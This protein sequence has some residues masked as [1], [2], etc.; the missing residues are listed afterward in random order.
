MKLRTTFIIPILA[1]VFS[2]V[3][4]NAQW[5]QQPFPSNENLWKVRFINPTTGWVLGAGNIYKTTDGGTSWQT[6]DTV[7]TGGGSAL[8]GLNNSIAFFAEFQGISGTTY[9]GIRKTS[10]GGISWRTVDT[11]QASYYDFDFVNQQTGFVVGGDYRQTNSCIIRKTTD[12][13]ESWQTVAALNAGSDFEGISFVDALHGWVVSYNGGLV[14]RTTDGGTS[15]AFQDNVGGNYPMRDIKFST[16]DSGWAIGGI[17]GTS[18]FAR[19]TN[20]GDSWTTVEQPGNT[21][22]E[23]TMVNSQLGWVV[24]HVYNVPPLKTTD[25]GVTWFQQQID[26]PIF[27]FDIYSISMVD[28]NLGWLAGL[29]GRVYKTMNGGTA[30]VTQLPTSPTR[31]HL[32]QNFPN[33]FNPST[34]I[35]FELPERSVV[36][37]IIFDPLGREVDDLIEGSFDAGSHSIMWNASNFSSGVYFVRMTVNDKS[38]V[39]QFTKTNKL[40][41]MK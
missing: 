21:L 9:R 1:T 16:P 41:L 32:D 11:L 23:I 22:E 35:R 13:G 15:W 29:G 5:L 6:Q 2:M 18:L 40:L 3:L 8:F 37:M 39:F 20:G 7:L 4:V 26:P 27:G 17:A 28:Q 34:Q 19:T 12:A 38:G 31:I 33:P 10:D 24:G 30:G 36:R 25:G 14:F